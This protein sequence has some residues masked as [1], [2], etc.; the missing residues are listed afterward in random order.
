MVGGGAEWKLGIELLQLTSNGK[1]HDGY[2]DGV[3]RH[4]AGRLSHCL[5]YVENRG[6]RKVVG[7]WARRETGT[8]KKKKSR[9]WM[10]TSH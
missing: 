8:L 10:A 7:G 3:F 9:D 6:D 4:P 5:I 2:G 1:M